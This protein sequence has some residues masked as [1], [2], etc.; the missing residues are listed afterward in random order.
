MGMRTFGDVQPGHIP[1][2]CANLYLASR[3]MSRKAVELG[4]EAN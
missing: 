2:K 1:G 4:F 3:T